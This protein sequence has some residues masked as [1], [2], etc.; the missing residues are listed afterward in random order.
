MF[1]RPARLWF[2]AAQHNLL[3]SFRPAALRLS[4]RTGKHLDHRIGKRESMIGAQALQILD[5]HIVSDQKDRHV[6]HHFARWRYLHDVAEGRSEE[7]TSELQSLR[8]L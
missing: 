7:H 1:S 3:H 2:R 8:H 5:R 6:T 4:E